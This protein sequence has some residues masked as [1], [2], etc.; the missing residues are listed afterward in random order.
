MPATPD[1]RYLSPIQ[2]RSLSPMDAAR[3]PPERSPCPSP[4]PV[5]QQLHYALSHWESIISVE[6][7]PRQGD[8]DTVEAATEGRTT[9][10][11]RVKF[12]LEHAPSNAS[13]QNPFGSMDLPDDTD[14]E[15]SAENSPAKLGKLLVPSMMMRKGIQLKA[16]KKRTFFSI[17]Q[18]KHNTQN[19]HK[20]QFVM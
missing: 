19:T 15:T 9:A 6:S 10:K 11:D 2:Q 7:S 18:P 4:T 13:S 17:E 5:F 12:I 3:N 8:C 16:N 20:Q 1:K 14:D